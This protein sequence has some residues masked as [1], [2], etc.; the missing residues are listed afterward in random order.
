MT[1]SSPSTTA[2]PRRPWRRSPH[3]ARRST[4]AIVDSPRATGGMNACV[5]LLGAEQVHDPYRTGRRLEG[6]P[7]GDRRRL[8]ELL[9]HEQRVEQGPAAAAVLLGEAMPSRPS[10]PSAEPLLVRHRP[11]AVP[12]LGASRTARR[13]SCRDLAQVVLLVG[14]LRDEQF[15]RAAC[16]RP[17]TN[18]ASEAELFPVVAGHVHVGR[19]RLDAVGRSE[20]PDQASNVC[21]DRLRGEVASPISRLERPRTIRLAI[22]R[23]RSESSSLSPPGGAGCCPAAAKTGRGRS[24]WSAPPGPRGLLDQ[25]V[26]GR[27]QVAEMVESS[28]IRSRRATRSTATESRW[29]RS[30][31]APRSSSVTGGSER[32]ST[33][34][35]TAPRLGNHGGERV[36]LQAQ[37]LEAGRRSP[38]APGAAPRR[39]GSPRPPPSRGQRRDGKVRRRSSSE[40]G[41]STPSVPLALSRPSPTERTIPRSSR[42][43]GS[44]DQAR[45]IRRR[46]LGALSRRWSA[47]RAPTGR[48]RCIAGHRLDASATGRASG[49][50][51]SMGQDYGDPRGPCAASI[52]LVV[53]SREQGPDD[54]VEAQVLAHRP[55]GMRCRRQDPSR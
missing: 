31:T 47:E 25:R 43:P 19:D 29:A 18:V 33:S 5:L 28:D 42:R 27:G 26:R 40:A 16:Y 54:R 9:D 11:L 1:I 10:S 7:G 48:L 39:G 55:A 36:V 14:Q 21:L 49:D 20:L 35:A 45:A 32:S 15:P 23:S 38:D 53:G 51:A 6:R 12:L 44:L 2:W 17:F 30:S 46:R 50:E 13:R 3:R 22:S 41:S 4:T 52:L 37:G 34:S 8:G 24:R